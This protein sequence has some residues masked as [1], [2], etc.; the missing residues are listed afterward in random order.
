VTRKKAGSLAGGK[1]EIEPVY[2]LVLCLCILFGGIVLSGCNVEE[3]MVTETPPI[4]RRQQVK[5]PSL[6]ALLSKEGDE[7]YEYDPSGRRDPFK[8]LI[9]PKKPTAT[10]DEEKMNCPPLQEFELASLKLVAIVW[11][12][13]GRKAML[14]A[15]NGRG[16]TVGEDMLVGRNCARVRRIESN[17]VIIEETRRDTEGHLLKEEVV[18]RLRERE[19]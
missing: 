9:A 1:R 19:G 18:L 11:G 14:K 7:P 16:Y 5:A 13:L 3:P 12:E 8:P 17:A 10:L 15:P 6:E 4:R 2:R